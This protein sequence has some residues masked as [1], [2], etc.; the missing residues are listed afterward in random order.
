MTTERAGILPYAG[1]DNA[2]RRDLQSI[3][4]R[5]SYSVAAS[6]GRGSSTAVS[7]TPTE[8]GASGRR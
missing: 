2:G 6:P 3:R 1:N 8:I 4:R 7:G 5:P